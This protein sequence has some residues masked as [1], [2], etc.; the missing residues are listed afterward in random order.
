LRNFADKTLPPRGSSRRG[1]EVLPVSTAGGSWT[2]HV[3]QPTGYHG[4]PAGGR[5]GSL[6]PSRRLAIRPGQALC[7]GRW[8]GTAACPAPRHRLPRAEHRRPARNPH[9]LPVAGTKPT[10]FQFLCGQLT[11]LITIRAWSGRRSP[12]RAPPTP[13][14]SPGIAGSHRARSGTGCP[15]AVTWDYRRD[16]LPST[17]SIT[18]S[19]A[20][21]NRSSASPATN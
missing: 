9:P 6:R 17:P 5:P 3:L 21:R 15:S 13:R 11:D 4:C 7:P 18:T 19:T 8:R 10:H 1:G 20:K 14:Y 16:A 2:Y 12:D